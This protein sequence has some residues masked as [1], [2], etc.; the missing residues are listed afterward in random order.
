MAMMDGIADPREQ[1]DALTN[2]QI[3]SGHKLTDRRRPRNELH[4]EVRHVTKVVVTRPGFIHLRDPGVLEAPED[5]RF[6]FEAALCGGR[7][8]P[9]AHQLERDSAARP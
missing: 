1:I 4:R 6:E 8:E 9:V 2:G 3:L 5:L 7:V